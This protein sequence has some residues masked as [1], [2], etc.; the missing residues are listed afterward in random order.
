MPDYHVSQVAA[1]KKGEWVT[2]LPERKHDARRLSGLRAQIVEK[3]DSLSGPRYRILGYIK[4][5]PIVATIGEEDICQAP[6]GR[7]A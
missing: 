4:N 6:E 3:C 5:H 1:R 7:A 2:L